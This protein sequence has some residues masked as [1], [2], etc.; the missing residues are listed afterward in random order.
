MACVS[1]RL[2]V[3]VVEASSFPGL[4]KRFGVTSVPMM[5]VADAVELVGTQSEAAVVDA[6]L[7]SQQNA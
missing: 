4:A 3:D 1:G 5:V 2:R 6:I 7:A